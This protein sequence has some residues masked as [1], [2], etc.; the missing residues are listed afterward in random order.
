MLLTPTVSRSLIFQL[1]SPIFWTDLTWETNLLV[2]QT[3]PEL[4]E[5]LSNPSG[6]VTC[7]DMHNTAHNKLI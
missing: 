1:Y 6:E 5:D 7:I 4:R 2:I 3:L